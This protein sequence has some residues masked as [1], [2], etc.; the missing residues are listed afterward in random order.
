MS[1]PPI[2]PA[3][4]PLCPDVRSLSGEP[5][6]QVHRFEPDQGMPITRPFQTATILTYRANFAGL[7][8]SQIGAFWTFFDGS[9]AR[10]ALPFAWIHPR[11]R[12]VREVRLIDRPREAMVGH[13]R[14]SLSVAVQFIDVAPAWAADVEISG[15]A[16]V[17]LP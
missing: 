8:E 7:T 11:L 14:W 4:M 12:E 13:L 2:W 9:I 10:G 3:A 1:V 6:D 15:G 16:I 5:Q 17:E